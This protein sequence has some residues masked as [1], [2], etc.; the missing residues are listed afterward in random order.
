M[1]ASATMVEMM[2]KVQVV[3]FETWCSLSAARL[4]AVLFLGSSSLCSAASATVA[5]WNT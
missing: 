5:S 4:R 1:P 2:P 3:A